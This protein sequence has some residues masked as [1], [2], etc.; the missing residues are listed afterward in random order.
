MV[1]YDLLPDFA[2][3]IAEIPP[4]F[5]PNERQQLL[6]ALARSMQMTLY[7]RHRKLENAGNLLATRFMTVK[8]NDRRTLWRAEPID[9]SPNTTAQSPGLFRRRRSVRA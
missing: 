4:F 9:R 7:G 6:Q 8:K 1:L 2:T 5:L 3:E